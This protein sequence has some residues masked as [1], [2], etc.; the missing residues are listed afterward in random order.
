MNKTINMAENVIKAL[1]DQVDKLKMA[2]DKGDLRQLTNNQAELLVAHSQWLQGVPGALAYQVSALTKR[3]QKFNAKRVALGLEANELDTSVILNLQYALTA[4]IVGANRDGLIMMLA[5]L[6]RE[7]PSC[8]HEPQSSKSKR[9]FGK[10]P[11][12]NDDSE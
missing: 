5:P 4:A 12:E 11:H 2:E 3:A 7:E 10:L 1:Q 8:S 9:R 6:F